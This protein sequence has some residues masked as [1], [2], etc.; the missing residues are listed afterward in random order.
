MPLKEGKIGIEDRGFQFAD[1]IYATIRVYNGVPFHIPEHLKRLE[2]SAKSI[3]LSLPYSLERIEGISL[4]LIA[5]SSI[6]WGKLYIQITRGNA[7]RAHVFPKKVKPTFLAYVRKMKPHPESCYRKGIKTITVP[8][9]RWDRP[10]IKSICLLPNVLAA[11]QARR[12]GAYEAIQYDEKGFVTEGSATNAYMMKKDILYTYPA[13][14]K[15]LRG[16]TRMLVFDMAENIGLTVKAAKKRVVDFKNADE[17]FISGSTV[18]VMPVVK[19]DQRTISNGKPGP[20]TR[21]LRRAFIEEVLA[22][23]GS[24]QGYAES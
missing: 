18:E 20:W 17:V 16:I 9:E 4:N 6:K 24:Y 10:H 13:K 8:D 22:Q 5:R 2:R 14:E 11:E 7:P 3:L 19:I 1:G 23:C 12:A 15:I 21:K